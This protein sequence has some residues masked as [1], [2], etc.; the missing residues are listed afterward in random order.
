M[1]KKPNAKRYNANDDVYDLLDYIN[2]LEDLLD[3][4]DQED[5][6]G[7]EGWRHHAGIE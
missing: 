6:F 1:K 2:I 4:A 3:E 5:F 7:T